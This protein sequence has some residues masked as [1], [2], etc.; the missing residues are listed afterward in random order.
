MQEHSHGEKNVAEENPFGLLENG[1]KHHRAKM[2]KT[3]T[4]GL[5]QAQGKGMA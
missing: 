3:G 1:T 2:A 5:D 4:Q